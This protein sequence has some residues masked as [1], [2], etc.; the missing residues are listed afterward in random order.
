MTFS[1]LGM[2][3]L[4]H[5]LGGYGDGSLGLGGWV[6]RRVGVDPRYNEYRLVPPG[7]FDCLSGGSV[8]SRLHN[9]EALVHLEEM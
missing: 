7:T 5:T 4:T 6:S 9:G 2:T 1:W 8:S 3:A